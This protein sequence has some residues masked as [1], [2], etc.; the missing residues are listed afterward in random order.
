MNKEDR[1]TK[2]ILEKGL[3]NIPSFDFTQNVL[4]RLPK[5]S[6]SRIKRHIIE[7]YYLLL[8]FLLGLS[9]SLFFF[10]LV[11][12]N[13]KAVDTFLTY[14]EFY[15]LP[16]TTIPDFFRLVFQIL[17]SLVIILLLPKL[18]SILW[19]LYRRTT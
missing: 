8:V 2:E 15:I 16:Y 9:L 17:S 10:Y 18:N 11:F 14:F 7:L 13:P 12:I 4:Q 6:P 3:L 1:M 19:K 5:E